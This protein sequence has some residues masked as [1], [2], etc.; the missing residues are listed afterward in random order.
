MSGARLLKGLTK[1]FSENVRLCRVKPQMSGYVALSWRFIL[2]YLVSLYH[3]EVEERPPTAIKPSP[4]HQPR[5]STTCSAGFSFTFFAHDSTPI[6]TQKLRVAGN[7]PSGA[8]ESSTLV[9]CLSFRE[10]NEVTR[11]VNLWFLDAGLKEVLVACKNRIDVR[12]DS[13]A[14]NGSVLYVPYL[15]FL[16]FNVHRRT[17]DLQGQKSLS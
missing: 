16:V 14:K 7:L 8:F 15:R 10:V 9:P 3:T 1:N 6:T 2:R 17:Y 13:G 4:E 5:Q 11:C 12:F